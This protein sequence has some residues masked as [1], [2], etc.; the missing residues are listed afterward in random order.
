MQKPTQSFYLDGRPRALRRESTSISG[1]GNV[2][3]ESAME[4]EGLFYAW[5]RDKGPYRTDLGSRWEPLAEGR[6]E[7]ILRQIRP[8]DFAG[9]IR[10]AHDPFHNLVCWA[11]STPLDPTDFIPRTSATLLAYNY[12]LG[13]WYPPMTGLHIGAWTSY[14]RETSVP[15]LGIFA[16]DEIGRLHRVFDPLAVRDSV[17]SGTVQGTL[18]HDVLPGLDQPIIDTTAAFYTTGQGLSNRRLAVCPP[19]GTWEW[20]FIAANDAM[21]VTP[22]G[23]FVQRMPAGSSYRIGAIDFYW[24]T[25]PYDAGAMTRQKRSGWLTVQQ[26]ARGPAVTA[27]QGLE[28]GVRID[29]D[30]EPYITRRFDQAAQAPLSLVQV[31]IADVAVPVGP[32]VPPEAVWVASHGGSK[33]LEVDDSIGAVDEDASTIS[34]TEP[35]CRQGVRTSGIDLPMRARALKVEVVVRARSS[36]PAHPDNQIAVRC[37]IDGVV[38]DERRVGPVTTTYQTF[39]AVFLSNPRTQVAWTR[40]DLV[41]GLTV[42]IE[43]TIGGALQTVVT[44]L[45]VRVVG[46]N[47]HPLATLKKR[48]QRAFYTAQL[49]FRNT[50]IDQRIEVLQYQLDADFLPRRSVRSGP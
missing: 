26:A 25:P 27:P 45:Y 6:I 23:A 47:G 39:T 16:V 4:I 32:G 18:T 24:W 7:T 15:S 50:D 10:I 40:E 19:G 28:V 34:T 17:P 38:S 37:L 36:D 3:Q 9:P 31:P 2:S 33:Y 5:D 46:F 29:T 41:T 44:Q 22:F 13:C 35:G 11:V 49:R 14:L 48:L 21:T 12:V 20:R 8:P 1:F 30:D 43:P 42:S